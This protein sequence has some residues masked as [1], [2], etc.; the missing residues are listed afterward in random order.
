MGNNKKIKLFSF[1]QF[2][3]EFVAKKQLQS[4]F[5]KKSDISLTK[6]EPVQ[7]NCHEDALKLIPEAAA[8]IDQRG[9]LLYLNPQA[10]KLLGRQLRSVLGR[11]YESVF[12]F[13]SSH[14][15]RPFQDLVGIATSNA[16]DSSKE[17]LLKV[18][19]T[20]FFPI[21]LNVLFLRAVE[22]DE[23]D[24]HYL[25][26]M[27]NITELKALESK[28][29]DLESFDGLTRLYNRKTFDASVKQLIENS[30][31][32]NAKHVLA[33]FSID[34]FQMMNDTFGHAGGDS[35]IKS[36]GDILNSYIR[37]GLDII[38][39][40]GGNQFAVVFC[41]S[42]VSYAIVQIKKILEEVEHYKFKSRGENYSVTL[43]AG[44]VIVDG[45]STSSTRVISEANL[46]CNLAA[47]RGGNNVCAY[48]AES[49]DIKKLEG[50]AEWVMVIK[51]AL[52]EGH[53][54]M[55][56][57]PI[58]PLLEYDYQKPFYHYE[59]LLR[60]FDEEGKPISPEEFISAA[61]YYSMMPTLDRWVV[62]DSLKQLSKVPKQEPMPVFA[63]NLS[64]QSLNDPNFLS[65]VQNE[66][67]ESRVIPEMLCFEI[68]EQVAVDDLSLV[69]KFIE[70]LKSIGVKFSLDDFGTGVSSFGYLK[71]LNVDY[72]KIDG[73]FVKN[74]AND[75]VARAMVQSINQVGHTMK[76]KVIAE[77][78][79]NA[80]I[81]ELLRE[82]GVDYGQGYHIAKPAPLDG[83]LGNHL[84]AQ[85]QSEAIQ[86]K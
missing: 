71:S 48:Q 85:K 50:N 62:R 74:I 33:Y 11:Q 44:F 19:K 38:G 82:M 23:S 73:S 81:L 12:Q 6:P 15:K 76:L 31:K 67:K 69:N 43:S 28:L 59:L 10:E 66:V 4:L 20:V 5:S 25:L 55:F 52:Q 18:G 49:Q 80:H 39:R 41:E 16:S 9:T 26:V 45:R 22:G 42:K 37:N 58:H 30:H 56:A 61:E 72:L 63:I 17:C 2:I 83:I 7:V 32:H 65:Y 57:Q 35:L 40:T 3:K 47:N 75:E 34:R 79:E 29:T 14:T 1:K 27:R 54:K 46:A 84:H 21:K 64:G 60:L 86:I 78:V 36:V 53:F 51:K 24:A 8:I 68:T 77:Y 70:S 13:L